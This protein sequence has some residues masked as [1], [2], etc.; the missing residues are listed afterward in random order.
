[1][2]VCESELLLRQQ[3]WPSAR[4]RNRGKSCDNDGRRVDP[5]R[6]CLAL[7]APSAVAASLAIEEMWAAL[8]NLLSFISKDDGDIAL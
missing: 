5:K 2:C 4:P 1:M 3:S 8:F 6:H 7:L